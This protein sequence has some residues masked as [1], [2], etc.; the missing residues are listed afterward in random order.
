MTPLMFAVLMLV[1]GEVQPVLA[2]ADN[3]FC[4]GVYD[5]CGEDRYAHPRTVEE[6]REIVPDE[7]D[8]YGFCRSAEHLAECLAK[9]NGADVE[10]LKKWLFGPGIRKFR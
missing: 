3:G 5:L 8:A 9:I 7:V 4:G 1:L 10:V 2:S 6:Y